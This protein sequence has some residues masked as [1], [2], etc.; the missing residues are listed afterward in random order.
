MTAK[1]RA[2][3]CTS[4][5]ILQRWQRNAVVDVDDEDLRSC[6]SLH[7]ETPKSL[8]PIIMPIG[9]HDKRRVSRRCQFCSR[10][11]RRVGSDHTLKAPYALGR[12]LTE[13]FHRVSATVDGHAQIAWHALWNALSPHGRR[14][15]RWSM[16]RP[17]RGQR[18]FNPRGGTSRS[19]SSLW[20]TYPRAPS[21]VVI[22]W[23]PLARMTSMS[24]TP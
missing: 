16:C 10:S 15:C 23:S 2:E 8:Q 3:L 13:P 14:S 21:C 9:I 24:K 18:W 6:E 4:C 7:S 17:V 11:H 12:V 20:D 22:W 19:A 5:Q 1:I